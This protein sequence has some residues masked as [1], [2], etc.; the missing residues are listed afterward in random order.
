[1]A[2][3]WLAQHWR[4]RGA[5]AART[6][7]AIS[8][9]AAALAGAAGLAGALLSARNLIAAS[10]LLASPREPSRT[11]RAV[12]AT[13]AGTVRAG[14][15]L[16]RAIP[17]YFWAFFLLA[18]LGPS[19]WPAVLALAIHN[20]GILGKLGAE[21]I[22]NVEPAPSAALRALGAGRA[23]LAL[24]ALL[25]TL[26]PRFLAFFF[27]RWE[28]C[29]REATVL[30]MLGIASLGFWV[31]DARARTHYDEMLFFVALGG[32][33]VLLGDLASALARA[34]LRRAA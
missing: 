1:M 15:A 10:P 11:R 26:L 28:T 8:I 6:T 5:E 27:Y 13:L 16:L 22:E 31:V 33:L 24:A 32:A 17:E 20:A 7:L 4:T 2:L 14:L 23:Q 3:G 9:V 12:W 25:P 21:L 30:G 18:G 19:A 29:V 34:A